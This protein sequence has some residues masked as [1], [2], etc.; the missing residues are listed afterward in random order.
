MQSASSQEE[1]L[2]EG[3]QRTQLLAEVAGGE[4]R[5]T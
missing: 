3:V 5:L 2:F 1:H 4:N